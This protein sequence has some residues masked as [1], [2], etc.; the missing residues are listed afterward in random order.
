M[1]FAATFIEKTVKTIII[2]AE[3]ADEAQ[4]VANECLDDISE[5][6]DFEKNPNDYDVYCDE[7]KE[8]KE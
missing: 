3:D 4:A 7:I 5:Y 2:E 1:K 8:V 6:I